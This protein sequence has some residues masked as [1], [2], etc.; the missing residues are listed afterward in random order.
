MDLQNYPTP[1]SLAQFAVSLFKNKR[2][3]RVLEP[4]AGRGDL[5]EA[6][7]SAYRHH[8]LQIDC[9]ELDFENQ[10]TLRGK[11]F[12]IVG[13]DFLAYAGG[14]IYSHILLNPPF[15][16]GDSHVLHAWD[17]LEDGEI[18]AIINA[19]TILNPFS[20]KRR[21]LVRLI[22][23]H[24][25]V[26]Y[27]KYAFTSNDTKRKT[28]VEV[29]IVYLKKE[30]DF[31]TEFLGTL[32]EDT[33]ADQLVGE[34]QNNELALNDKFISNRVTA[35]NCA[36]QALSESVN[37]GIR[38][39][40]YARLLGHSIFDDLRCSDEPQDKRADQFNKAYLQLKERAW[41]S[42]LRSTT[43]IGRLGSSA[44][45]RLE[46][47]FEKITPLAFTEANIYGFL[48]GLLLQQSDLQVEMMCDVFDQFSKYHPNNRVYYCGWKSNAKHRVNAFR[49]KM[50]RFIL[51][52]LNSSFY[53][54]HIPSYLAWD[55]E[56]R[57]HDFDKVFAML[58]CKAENNIF[59]LR[60]LFKQ[61]ETM[62]RLAAGERIACDYFEVRFFRKSGTFHLFPTN[63]ELIERLNRVVGKHRAWLPDEPV[64]EESS[65]WQQYASAEKACRNIKLT[66]NDEWQLKHGTGHAVADKLRS[67]FE[68]GLRKLG[69]E[70]DP[71][72][73]IETFEADSLPRP[74]AA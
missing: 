28:D 72:R 35:F 3:S 64:P 53:A 12:S 27:K 74:E 70:Y 5:A 67:Q 38:A 14:P 47:E 24:G 68:E 32:E 41:S 73:A 31:N 42:I 57:F 11:E 60:K 21:H 65:F 46:A 54:S 51:P 58:D 25:H 17:L 22:E 56:R 33:A 19:E 61:P 26:S 23:D 8:R 66:W 16:H 40:H 13:H 37:A 48:E 69:I 50:N 45:K 43:V 9:V 15:S 55:D 49:L 36:V 71:D 7:K 6:L 39:D 34:T 18:V 59:G 29:A 10:S 63:K 20:Q 62:K 2:F 1:P 4:S 30:S 44:Q 52:A